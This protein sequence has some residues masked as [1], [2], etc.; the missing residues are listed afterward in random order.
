[1]V[2]DESRP[3][4][5]KPTFTKFGL[6]SIR[7]Q[8]ELFWTKLPLDLKRCVN[9]NSFGSMLMT[10]DVPSCSCGYCILY[11]LS[12]LYFTI[13]YLY[14][15]II[16]FLII[17]LVWKRRNC[18]CLPQ[19][20]LRFCISLSMCTYHCHCLNSVLYYH[21]SAFLL[22][23]RRAETDSAEQVSLNSYDS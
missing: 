8:G 15:R 22:V 14:V 12:H 2:L 3:H 11:K 7:Y 23:T 17:G 16:M 4:Q 18:V 21:L 9:C 5:H 20:L 19:Q 6:N 10:R 13:I 1:M